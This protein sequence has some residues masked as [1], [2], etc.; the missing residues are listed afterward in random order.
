K[1]IRVEL[2]PSGGPP[3]IEGEFEWKAG[4]LVS[5]SALRTVAKIALVGFAHRFGTK[6][7]ESKGFDRVKAFIVDG[8]G[9]SPVTLFFSD[10]FLAKTQSGPHQHMILFAASKEKRAIWAIVVL[11]GGLSYLVQLSD[12]WEGP[13]LMQT[14]CVDA[15]K[16]EEPIVLLAALENELNAVSLVLGEKTTWSNVKASADGFLSTFT[17][18]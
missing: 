17:P 2:A 6:I 16:G 1:G 8:S 18:S 14:Y 7:I 13:D 10:E 4:F 15:Q 5:E 3:E 11:F 9:N 12:S